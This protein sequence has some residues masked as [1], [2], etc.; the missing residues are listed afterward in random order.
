MSKPDKP[1]RRKA[2]GSIPHLPGSRLGPG[3]HT[4]DAGQAK[5]CTKKVRD[6]KDRVVVQEKLDGSCVAVAMLNGILTPL[7]RSGY[8]ALT[9]PF[10]QHHLFHEWVF[11][12]S[13]RFYE[14]LKEGERIVGEWLA[15]A[16]GTMY[17]LWHDPFVPFDI[18]TDSTRYNYD[19]FVRRCFGCFVVP[20]VYST[21]L[22][23]QPFTAFQSIADGYYHG[24]KGSPEGLV[25][26]VERDGHVDFLA[27]WVRPDKVDG[28]FLESETGKEPVW[29]WRPEVPV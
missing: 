8:P 14:V 12:N 3:D 6:H 18:M 19:T 9:S 1:I 2:Y 21:H 23:V 4:I 13:D 7:Q 16:H 15:Q 20:A 24:A 17:D 5:I 10:E 29:N 22:P 28:C 27:K 26:R 25:Y 11:E